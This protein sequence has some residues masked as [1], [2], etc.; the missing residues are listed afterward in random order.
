MKVTPINSSAQIQDALDDRHQ[1]EMQLIDK[2][3]DVLEMYKDTQMNLA[4]EAARDEIAT[5]IVK[6]VYL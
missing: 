4:S 3:K 2:V 5:T 1:R 6:N